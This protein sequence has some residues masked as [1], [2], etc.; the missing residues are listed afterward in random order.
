MMR[1]ARAEE[2]P[3]I[4]DWAAAEGW[5]PGLD[6]AGA[7]YA[8]DPEGFFVAEREGVPVAAISVVNH[9]PYHAFLGLYICHPDW[10]GKGIGHALWTHALAHAEGRSI[11]LDGVAAQQANYAKSGFVRHGATQRFVGTLVAEAHPRIRLVTLADLPALIAFDHAAGG[12]H[13][14][15]FLTAWLTPTATRRAVMFD[16]GSGFAV[17]RTCR[18]G[19]KVGPILAPDAIAALALAQAAVDLLPAASTAIDLPEQNASLRDA[20]IAHGFT[21]GFETAR[22]YRGPAPASDPRLAAIATMELG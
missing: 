8:A 7:F 6:D 11:G 21:L 15:A 4:L 22:M 3:L 9:D 17:I 20:L 2:L 16:D 1:I 10:R 18:E 13:R 19:T 12:V 5:N 14:P